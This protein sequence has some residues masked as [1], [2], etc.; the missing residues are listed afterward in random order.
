MPDPGRPT[1]RL[2]PSQ[3]GTLAM[4]VLTSVGVFLL[5][6]ALAKTCRP[7]PG[8]PPDV[9][10]EVRPTPDVITAVRGLVRLETVAYH[11]ERVVDLRD[12]QQVLGGLLEAE[13]AIL[14]VAAG[15]VIAGVDLEKL[16]PEDVEVDRAAGRV[17]I[18][19]P[20]PEI[21][22]SSLDNDR[23]FVYARDTDT[24]ARRSETLETRARQEAERTLT[25]AALEAGVLARAAR[26]ASAAVEGLVR[27]LGY[28]DVQVVVGGER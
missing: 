1:A 3:R 4:R 18:R 10:Q 11:G 14:L 8:P 25:Q 2:A 20:E 28:P 7:E 12:W 27:G 22:A 26:G 23:T 9:V 6:A 21:L 13:D 5:G 17:R 19:L 24:L 15:D 16:R